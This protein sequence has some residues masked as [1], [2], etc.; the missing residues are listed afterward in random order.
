MYSTTYYKS[1]AVAQL[2]MYKTNISTG[3]FMNILAMVHNDGND[4]N[5]DS[6]SFYF[7]LA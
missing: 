7:K 5:V 1:T 6:V 3:L 4:L 2:D